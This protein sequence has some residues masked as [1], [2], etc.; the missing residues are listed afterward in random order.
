MRS[1]PEYLPAHPFFAGLDD[2]W[3]E[4]VT[5]CAVNAH[6]RSRSNGSSRT[7]RSMK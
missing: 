7:P 2:R 6:F 3:I 1:I 4:L 5:G